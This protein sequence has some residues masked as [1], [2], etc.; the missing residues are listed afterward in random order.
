ALGS[1]DPDDPLRKRLDAPAPGVVTTDVTVDGARF[2]RPATLDDALRLLR[3]EPD[4]LAVAGATDWGVEVNLRGRRT[5][6]VVAI[7]QLGELRTLTVTDDVIELG[8]ALTLS[9]I[10]QRLDGR[11]PLLSQL[12]PQ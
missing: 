5:P 4:A 2:V 10:E 1:P 9:E 12:F 7:E 6:L 11:V 8:A 3:D